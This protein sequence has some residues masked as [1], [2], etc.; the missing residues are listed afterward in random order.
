MSD[1]SFFCEYCGHS[2]E[3]VE[4]CEHCGH[5]REP[6]AEIRFRA[7]A[8]GRLPVQLVSDHEPRREW[9]ALAKVWKERVE[10]LRPYPL[11]SQME[12]FDTSAS[13]LELYG[14]DFMGEILSDAL[15]ERGHVDFQ[16][17]SHEQLPHR[18]ANPLARSP[19]V[20]RRKR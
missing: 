16:E 13:S 10:E 19:A 7:P 2:G 17:L 1:E 15:G 3:R 14:A 6:P 12:K 8:W 11:P 9:P 5:E 20:P 4:R 18:P